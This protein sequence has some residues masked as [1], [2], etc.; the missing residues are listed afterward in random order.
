MLVILKCV[1]SAPSPAFGVM[2]RPDVVWTCALVV[3]GVTDG[4]SATA[5][6]VIVAVTTPP[7]SP[8][9]LALVEACRS[10]DAVPKK[11]GRR[12]ELQAGRA[13]RHRDEAAVGD[14]R[15]PVGQE[16]RAVGDI[17]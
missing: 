6:T 9:A 11:F 2:T 5:L 4:V 16:H 3:A 1:T 15:R 7:P 17:R 14:G 13:L 10:K 8:P 12:R